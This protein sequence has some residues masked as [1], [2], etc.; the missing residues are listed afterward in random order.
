[1]G[2]ISSNPV[3]GDPLESGRN[4]KEGG[5]LRVG[6]RGKGRALRGVHEGAGVPVGGSAD[7]RRAGDRGHR[8]FGKQK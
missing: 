1:M 4:T 6:P 3:I 7:G 8:G 2:A 5:R